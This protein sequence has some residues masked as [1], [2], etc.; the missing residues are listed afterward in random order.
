MSEI[1][2]QQA[3][4]DSSRCDTER[5]D[6]RAKTETQRHSKAS[7]I[8]RRENVRL[9]SVVSLAGLV[10]ERGV[11]NK[12]GQHGDESRCRVLPGEE[13][14]ATDALHTPEVELA[15]YL[16]YSRRVA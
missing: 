14:F 11:T 8:D 10:V 2:D 9:E 4:N 5:A 12:A 3:D 7:K 6:Q 13:M 15:R 16:T 1:A